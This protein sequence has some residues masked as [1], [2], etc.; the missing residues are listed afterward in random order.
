MRDETTYFYNLGLKSNTNINNL[1][2]L[3]K[4]FIQL[5]YNR[6]AIIYDDYKEL[7]KHEELAN[8]LYSTIDDNFLIYP[9]FHIS[10]NTY[11]KP[12]KKIGRGD[13]HRMRRRV[14]GKA[15]ILSIDDYFFKNML[16][17]NDTH[18]FDLITLVSPTFKSLIKLIKKP[19]L[20]EYLVS[21]DTVNHSW[22]FKRLHIIKLLLDN[23]KLIVSPGNSLYTPLQLANYIYGILGYNFF[24]YN[25]VS[26]LPIKLTEECLNM[27]GR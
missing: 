11:S 21:R 5:G 2:K 13:I 6:F 9:R 4:A 26:T 15:C 24:S 16:N 12:L 19:I 14:R 1:T 17:P 25:V 7:G 20:F 3:V 22:L 8:H 27:V 10:I 23:D 18:K